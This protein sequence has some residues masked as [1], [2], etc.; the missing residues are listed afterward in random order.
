MICRSCKPVRQQRLDHTRSVA[1]RKQKHSFCD[2][3]TPEAAARGVLD[4]M[5]PVIFKIERLKSE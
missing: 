5:K 1:S 2:A 4:A 3:P